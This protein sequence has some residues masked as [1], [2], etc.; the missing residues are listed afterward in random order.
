MFDETR[1]GCFIELGSA[2]CDAL[3]SV[4]DANGKM[5]LLTGGCF[6]ILDFGK[7]L[8]NSVL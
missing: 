3:N 7:I 8:L 2:F 6:S 1:R 5:V 4:S